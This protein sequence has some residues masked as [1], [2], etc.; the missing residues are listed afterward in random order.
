MTAAVYC[1]LCDLPRTQCQHGLADRHRQAAE[2]AVRGGT[3][4]MG[5]KQDASSATRTRKCNRCGKRKRQ[6]RFGM[7]TGC[8][9]KN[10]AKMCSQCKK[11]F[12]A[13][14]TAA[15]KKPICPSCRKKRKR[16]KGSV[17]TVASA[18]APTLGKRH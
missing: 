13:D 17:W 9:L 3:T 16:G 10:G 11:A 18:G 12:K 5:Q 2:S 1:E 7:C 6:G 15:G 8:L 14:D 4:A